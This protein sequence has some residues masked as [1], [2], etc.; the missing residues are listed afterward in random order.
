MVVETWLEP[1]S[2]NESALMQ[3]FDPTYLRLVAQ[4]KPVKVSALTTLQY[5][6]REEII[7]EFDQLTSAII[8]RASLEACAFV[9]YHNNFVFMDNQV[10]RGFKLRDWISKTT[11]LPYRPFVASY[12]R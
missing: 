10:D 2:I 4:N 9:P 11:I 3:L 1:V 8:S 5:K 7:A 6:D 12:D